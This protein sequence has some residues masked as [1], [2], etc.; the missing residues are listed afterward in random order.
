MEIEVKLPTPVE[1][2]WILVDADGKEVASSA[3]LSGA[4]L[5]FTPRFYAGQYSQLLGDV[6]VIGAK[7]TVI[8][9]C[10]RVSASAGKLAAEHINKAPQP[11]IPAFDKKAPAK[12][13]KK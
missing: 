10:L 9:Q 5:K 13:D 3:T 4:T 1:A 12:D 11:I 6:V 7:G 2:D 8:E